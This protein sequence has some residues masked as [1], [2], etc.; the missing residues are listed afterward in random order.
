LTKSWNA[1]IKYDYNG[2]KCKI[3]T[4]EDPIHI[5]V[6]FLCSSSFIQDESR[7]FVDVISEWLGPL[8]IPKIGLHRNI[9]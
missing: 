5:P 6:Y 8:I 4:P 3:L 9:L 7:A 2:V 1:T